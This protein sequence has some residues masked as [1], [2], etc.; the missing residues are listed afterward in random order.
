MS[1]IDIEFEKL[2]KVKVIKDIMRFEKDIGDNEKV[3]RTCESDNKKSLNWIK[4]GFKE[5]IKFASQYLNES[6]QPSKNGG[7]ALI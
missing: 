3:T 5:G 2:W 7:E 1:D 6:Q 4:Y